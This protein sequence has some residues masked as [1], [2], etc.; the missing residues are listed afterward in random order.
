MSQRSIPG[1]V[2]VTQS[3]WLSL[4]PVL[5]MPNSV[6]STHSPSLWLTR[7]VPS[8]TRYT[9]YETWLRTKHVCTVLERPDHWSK[10]DGGKGVGITNRCTLLCLLNFDI[11]ICHVALQPA[12]ENF[13]SSASRLLS[14][15]V[16]ES[17]TCDAWQPRAC[18]QRDVSPKEKRL[19]PMCCF[20][21]AAVR[22]SPLLNSTLSSHWTLT[23][24]INVLP[25]LSELAANCALL[26][27][28]CYF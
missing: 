2:P 20:A 12:D 28:W 4:L 27:F 24:F 13:F 3:V 7:S 23:S 18:L 14:L 11:S 25:V 16:N 17:D 21:R 9:M 19:D 1:D 6:Y 8:F 10:A 26:R 22:L 5:K 15:V